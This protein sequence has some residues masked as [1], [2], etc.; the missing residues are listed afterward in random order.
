MRSTKAKP[1]I[2][3]VTFSILALVFIEPLWI[4]ISLIVST[5]FLRLVY[6]FWSKDGNNSIKGYFLGRKL[7]KSYPGVKDPEQ[8]SN[9]IVGAGQLNSYAFYMIV[10]IDE[11]GVLLK[12]NNISDKLVSICWDD[13]SI[14]E[15]RKSKVT[16]DLW[17]ARLGLRDTYF[18]NEIIIPWSNNFSDVVPDSVGY[19][20]LN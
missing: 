5:L 8:E 11:K 3:I 17:Y 4:A 10:A 18:I 14:I 20:I 6:I 12:I 9:Q 15:C 16:P 19:T 2:F 7:S 13:I 1:L